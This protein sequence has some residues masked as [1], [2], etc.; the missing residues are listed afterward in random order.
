MT[1]QIH[2]CQTCLD[3]DIARGE[4]DFA[5]ALAV[6]LQ[7]NPQGEAF[8]L[9]RQSCLG[10][11]AADANVAVM[12]PGRW[13]WLFR[14][15]RAVEDLADFGVFLEAWRTASQGLPAKGDRPPSLRPK[16]A[17]RLPPS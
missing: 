9:V 10:M 4:P 1:A 7:Q 13:G 6:W 17:G 11:C 15:L 5:A 8:E 12:A 16:T 14:G 2:I 3:R